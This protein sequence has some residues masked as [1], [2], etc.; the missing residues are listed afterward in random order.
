MACLP[1]HQQK[2]SRDK[3]TTTSHHYHH[4]LQWEEEKEQHSM[5]ERAM[6]TKA[7]ATPFKLKWGQNSVYS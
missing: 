5:V 3:A 7:A 6:S 2:L 4:H 1:P